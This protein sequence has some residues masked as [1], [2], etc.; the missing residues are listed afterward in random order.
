[1]T[2]ASR[3]EPRFRVVEG[4]GQAQRPPGPTDEELVAAV[5]SGD[6]RVARELYDRVIGVVDR[7]LFRVFGRREHDHDDLVQASFEQIVASLVRE[8]FA[9]ACSL[10]TWAAT[11]ATH[12]GLNA[13]RARARERKVVS[14]DAEPPEPRS[15]DLERDLEARAALEAV[16]DALA[17]MSPDKAQTLFL[18]DV[19]GLELAE[20]AALTG[21]TVAAA[22]SR[23]VRARKELSERVNGGGHE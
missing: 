15:R 23:L 19:E 9:G 17:A 11:L 20:I 21:A 18:H 14:R 4:G 16:R 12:V 5:R 22:Q 7:T 3:T 6:A 1:M 13:L 10:S 8:R 2:R